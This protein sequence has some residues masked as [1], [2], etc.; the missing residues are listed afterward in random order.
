MLGAV[1]PI[2]LLRVFFRSWNTS[3]LFAT[4]WNLVTELDHPKIDNFNKTLLEIRRS[5][6]N[7]E[8]QL[9]EKQNETPKRSEVT[10]VEETVSG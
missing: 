10:S 2:Y 8:Y 4:F 1:F 7:V 6:V 5:S 9:P 3:P